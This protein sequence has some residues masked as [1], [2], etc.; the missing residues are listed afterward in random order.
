MTTTVCDVCGKEMGSSLSI[1]SSIRDYNFCI[2]SYGKKWDIC[3]ECREE[4]NVWMNEL[5]KKANETA[6]EA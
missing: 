4:L 1:A 2:S 6:R 3:N 5:R